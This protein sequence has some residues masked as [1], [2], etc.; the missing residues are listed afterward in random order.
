M[1]APSSRKRYLSVWLRRLMTDR[2]IRSGRSPVPADEPAHI[3]GSRALVIVEPVKG[4]LRLAGMNDAA[5]GLGLRPGM[6][7]ADARAMYPRIAAADADPEADRRML[8]A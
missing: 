7:L 8:S 2:L 4:A 5:D 3:D 6:A 1:P